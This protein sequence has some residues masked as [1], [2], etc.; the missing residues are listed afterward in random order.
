MR[1][2]KNKE[3][4]LYTIFKKKKKTL[5]KKIAHQPLLIENRNYETVTN[6]RENKDGKSNCQYSAREYYILNGIINF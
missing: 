5:T 3:K 4:G 1:K 2:N 6:D